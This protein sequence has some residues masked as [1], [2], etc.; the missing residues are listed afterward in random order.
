MNIIKI[1][2]SLSPHLTTEAQAAKSAGIEVVILI[3]PGNY[4]IEKNELDNFKSIN[5]FDELDEIVF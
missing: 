3:R 5:S 1:S 4:P 2:L